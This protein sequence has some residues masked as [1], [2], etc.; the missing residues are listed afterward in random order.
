MRPLAI[1]GLVLAL[2]VAG[3]G[4]GS[5]DESLACDLL[6][7]VRVAEVMAA[8]LDERPPGTRT[9]CVWADPA[10]RY[11]SLSFLGGTGDDFDQARD[12]T[13]RAFGPVEDV[14]DVGR[15]AFGLSAV[16]N[17]Y[18]LQVLTADRILVITV[19]TPDGD[20][21]GRAIELARTIVTGL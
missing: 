7:P 1:L 16:E 14:P 17:G 20:Q 10:D 4:D 11:V 12:S 21:K 19:V 18:T 2:T 15:A 5:E 9:D 8:D 3:C 13:E 6:T